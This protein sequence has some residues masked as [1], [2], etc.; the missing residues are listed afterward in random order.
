MKD[1]TGY[2]IMPEDEAEVVRVMIYWIYHDEICIKELENERNIDTCPKALEKPWGKLYVIGQKY[3]MPRLQNAA[4]DAILYHHRSWHFQAGILPWV[5]ENT[6][7]GDNLRKLVFRNARK[8]IDTEHF[9]F[10]GDFFC[11]EFL[12]DMEYASAQKHPRQLKENEALISIEDPE[13]DIGAEFHVKGG[14][15]GECENYKSYTEFEKRE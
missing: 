13:A 1:K 12:F 8:E 14:C 10:F 15:D 3:Q 11:R 4:I 5:Y 9:A 6:N 2:I 7:Q